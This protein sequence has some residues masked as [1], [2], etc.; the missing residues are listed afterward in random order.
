MVCTFV[1]DLYIRRASCRGDDR[2]VGEMVMVDFGSAVW[3]VVFASGGILW[4]EMVVLLRSWDVNASE[5]TRIS[6]V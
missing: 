6:S 1:A 3:L 2:E 5:G 4:A